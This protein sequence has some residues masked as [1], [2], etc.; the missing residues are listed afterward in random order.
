MVRQ[1]PPRAGHVYVTHE[2]NDQIKRYYE[3]VAER[4]AALAKRKEVTD[5]LERKVKRLEYEKE[6]LELNANPIQE[7]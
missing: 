1:V 2:A 4:D 3:L 5:E 7:G 6:M